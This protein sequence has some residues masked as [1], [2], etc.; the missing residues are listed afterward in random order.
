M[1]NVFLRL[2]VYL[3]LLRV[4]TPDLLK[5]GIALGDQLLVQKPGKLRNHSIVV[6]QLQDCLFIR[7]IVYHGNTPMVIDLTGRTA[8]FALAAID[9]ECI[10]GEVIELKRSLEVEIPQ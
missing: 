10:L 2:P 7:R 6:I 1:L 4:T 9:K 8:S 5:S 3:M